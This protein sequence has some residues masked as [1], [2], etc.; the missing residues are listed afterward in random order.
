M[1]IVT[2]L[3]GPH[4]DVLLDHAQQPNHHGE[5]PVP[6]PGQARVAKHKQAHRATQGRGQAEV[7]QDDQLLNLERRNV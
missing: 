3:H 6:G 1:N 2:H 5:D 7:K 4:E